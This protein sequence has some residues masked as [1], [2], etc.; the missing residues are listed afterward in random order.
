MELRTY[1]QEASARTIQAIYKKENPVISMATGTG[2]S[3][4]IS[5]VVRHFAQL[6]RR[7]WVLTHIQQLVKQNSDTY[8]N[9]ADKN[10]GIVCAGMNRKQIYKPIIFG[11]IQSMIGVLK[12]IDPPDMRRY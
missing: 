1:Q 11:T 5:E 4:I 12:E 10:F 3:L 7:I 8:S 9:Y 2:K 6:G